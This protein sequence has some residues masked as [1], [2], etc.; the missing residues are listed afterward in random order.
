MSLSGTMCSR[1]LKASASSM[2]KTES[3]YLG[4]VSTLHIQ[5]QMLALNKDHQDS[6]DHFRSPNLELEINAR[7]VT[8]K[9]QLA[10][11]ALLL[12]AKK[13]DIPDHDLWLH[14][15]FEKIEVQKPKLP[16]D[17]EQ[18]ATELPIS[19]RPVFGERMDKPKKK[20]RKKNG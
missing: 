12:K 7:I 10:A 20:A 3:E 17:L 5:E 14:P 16:E 2:D 11:K 8:I 6:E 18:V 13:L 4:L 15:H 19:E 9:R 1:R